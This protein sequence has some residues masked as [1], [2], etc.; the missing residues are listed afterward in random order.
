MIERILAIITLAVNTISA[1]FSKKSAEQNSQ[2]KS[3]NQ[4]ELN[5]KRSRVKCHLKLIDRVDLEYEYSSS[6]HKK[7]NYVRLYIIAFL[8]LIITGIIIVLQLNNI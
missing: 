1:Y 7:S 3:L 5:R 8:G 2:T 4:L 6:E